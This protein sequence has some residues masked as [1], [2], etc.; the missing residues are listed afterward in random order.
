LDKNIQMTQRDATNTAW[1][2]LNP[3]TIAANI[4]VADTAA[5]FTETNTE[6][7]LAELFTFANDG[8]TGIASAVT[9]KGVAASSADTFPALATKI[10]QITT[11]SVLTGNMVA[12]DLLLGKTGYSNNPLTKLTGTIPNKATT[13]ITPSTANQTIAA[14]QYLSGIQT[15]LGDNDLQPFNIL[16]GRTIFNVAGTVTVTSLGGKKFASGSKTYVNDG[17]GIVI[18]G[19]TFK[20]SLVFQMK[21]QVPNQQSYMIRKNLFGNG[22]GFL[23]RMDGATNSYSLDYI[24]DQYE[25][26]SFFEDGFQMPNIN[27]TEG[28]IYQWIAYE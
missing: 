21:Q 17:L 28:A 10:G 7:V 16:S 6:T 25:P 27:P 15:I 5:H 12:A 3:K 11:Q 24:E 22:Y 8:K 13:T 14:G 2:N 1:D 4:S 26:Q 20:P 23:G 18:H 19:L 9:A